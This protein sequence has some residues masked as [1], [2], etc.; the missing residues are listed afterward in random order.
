[1]EPFDPATARPVVA[2][3]ADA[4]GNKTKTLAAMTRFLEASGTP[5][6]DAGQ[7]AAYQRDRDFMLWPWR[8]LAAAAVR[9]NEEGQHD[10][11]AAACFFTVAWTRT[12]EPEMTGGDYVVAGIGKAPSDAVEKITAA[13]AAAIRALPD[14]YVVS[15]TADG[16]AVT[17]AMLAKVVSQ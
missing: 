17:C 6:S 4:T 2:A 11:A 9:A 7:M 12:R 13:G 3:L 15:N 16:Y 5:T 14:D 8:W 10:V 1:M